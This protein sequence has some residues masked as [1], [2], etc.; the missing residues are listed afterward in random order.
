MPKNKA[1]KVNIGE[2]IR[3]KLSGNNVF[4]PL[5]AELLRPMDRQNQIT[6][7]SYI[8]NKLKDRLKLNSLAAIEAYLSRYINQDHL[9]RLGESTYMVNPHTAFKCSNPEFVTLCIK[10]DVEKSKVLVAENS[11]LRAANKKLKDEATGEAVIASVNR[12]LN[13]GDAS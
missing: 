7:N 6:L 12:I 2:T 9:I 11:K 3:M 10:Y 8:K 1:I 13:E 5:L 4:A